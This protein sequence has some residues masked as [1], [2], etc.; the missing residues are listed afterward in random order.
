MKF[1]IFFASLLLSTSPSAEVMERALGKFE[2][3]P[4]NCNWPQDDST[5]C[6]VAW[7]S[8]KYAQSWYYIPVDINPDLSPVDLKTNQDLLTVQQQKRL[9]YFF[10][11]SPVMA[12]L[13]IKNGE[14]AYEKYQYGRKPSD[15]FLYMSMSKS[16][17]ALAVGKAIELG[18]IKGI[19][20][21]VS[22]YLPELKD[23]SYGDVSI[24]HLL[25]M[26]SG[27]GYDYNTDSANSDTTKLARIITG[28]MNISFM[29]YIENYRKGIKPRAAGSKFNYDDNA[30]VLLGK[31]VEKASSQVLPDF[32]SQ[33]I[34]SKIGSHD[35]AIWRK[36]I[37]G[38][39]GANF[40][41][42]STAR[43]LAQLGIVLINDGRHEGNQIIQSS[44]IQAQTNWISDTS[45]MVGRTYGY[46][47]QTWI[48]DK[49]GNTFHFRGHQ[50]QALYADR[51]SKTLLIAFSVDAA[52]RN[53]NSL[54]SLFDV[55]KP[56][57]QP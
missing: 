12:L 42:F 31:I 27:V 32:F 8:G 3:Y 33:H 25:E 2:N 35:R 23:S 43:D 24:R 15:T 18:I 22:Q 56:N 44:W 36:N 26:R 7:N 53:W 38:D 14:I 6:L 48:P 45:N 16:I 9:D 39:F 1:L 49:S 19:D 21:K 52:N 34:W 47:Y 11:N 46:G 57:K 17:T 28:G 40:S 13:V 50:G 20:D 5:K 54:D 55:V 4:N 10:N 41:F 51:K 37:R 29:T 30:T